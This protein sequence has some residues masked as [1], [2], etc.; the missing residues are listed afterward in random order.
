MEIKRVPSLRQLT[1]LRRHGQLREWA[2]GLLRRSCLARRIKKTTIILVVVLRMD[3]RICT[4]MYMYT[5]IYIDIVL[6]LHPLSV[7][8][9]CTP[10]EPSSDCLGPYVGSVEGPEMELFSSRTRVSCFWQGVAGL[11]RAM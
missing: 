9:R 5:Y 10:P 2:E 8:Y 1:N 11:P 4:D 7:L 3:F 6:L